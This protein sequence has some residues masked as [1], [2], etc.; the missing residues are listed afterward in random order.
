MDVFALEPSGVAIAGKKGHNG[1]AD[2]FFVVIH[3]RR[4]DATSR[5]ATMVGAESVIWPYAR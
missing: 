5:L 2:L 1:T 4:V 3:L